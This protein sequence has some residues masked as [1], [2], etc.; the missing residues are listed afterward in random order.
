MNRFSFLWFF[1]CLPLL[2]SAEEQDPLWSILITEPVV[3]GD[4]NGEGR[5]FLEQLYHRFQSYETHLLS[6]KEIE[7]SREEALNQKRNELLEEMDKLI[8]ERDQLLYKDMPMEDKDRGIADLRL[9]L[10]RLPGDYSPMIPEEQKIELMAYSEESP[11]FP[12]RRE[13]WDTE[14]RWI[15]HSLLLIKGDYITLELIGENALTGESR[16]LWAASGNLSLLES[17]I[18]PA[19]QA[20]RETLLGRPWA[21][22]RLDLTP[23]DT[24]VT[25]K[26]DVLGV[27]RIFLP[28]LTP[29][30][31][32]LR[33]SSEGYRE[34]LES[35]ELQAGETLELNIELEL[36]ST[37]VSLIISDPPGA[38]VYLGSRW[39]GTTPLELQVPG[40]NL[41][42]LLKKE[43]YEQ[44]FLP[45]ESLSEKLE[46]HMRPLG[47]DLQKEVE[48]AR[49]K[50]YNSLAVFGVSLA[51]PIVMQGVQENRGTLYLK[52]LENYNASKTQEDY[53]KAQDAFG[54]YQLSYYT[55]G[56]S[57][58]ISGA[59][60][61]HSLYRLYRYIR[62]S[63]QAILED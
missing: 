24:V 7:A 9:E 18:E 42:L 46:I 31:L 28:G 6:D 50:L 62:L 53:E 25:S 33:F 43:D 8:S 27:G 51:F 3:T 41:S 26:D 45:S 29:G 55:Y 40:E 12:Y 37:P 32:D 11:L 47:E 1:F 48:T 34:T 39:M 21:A 23:A 60:L 56:V 5:A 58:G 20:C 52:Y 22:L 36:V 17:W 15:L 61:A 4:T 57:L 54:E 19:D 30:S 59:L 14:P 49:K 2:L 13:D 63:E 38:D 10:E 35:L 44:I 16:E